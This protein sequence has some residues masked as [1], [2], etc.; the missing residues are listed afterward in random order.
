[1]DFTVHQVQ[2]KEE[3][4][5]IARIIL[6][7]L[8]DWFGIPEYREQYIKD[9]AE[10]EFFCAD[11]DDG[12]KGFLCL[13]KTGDAT[14]ELAVMGVDPQYHHMGLGTALF[15]SAKAKARDL[16]FEFI[17]VKTVKEG[18]YDDYDITNA[19][20]RSLGFKEFECFPLY[21]DEANPCQIYVM[22]IS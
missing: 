18:M 20:Y 5:Q 3:K 16:G 14:V 4:V 8:T 17:Q 6:E 7:K 1:M 15:D 10:W 22:H 11:T 12:P 21:W 9:S 2:S 13:K 19:F